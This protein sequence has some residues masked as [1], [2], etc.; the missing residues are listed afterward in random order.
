MRYYSLNNPLLWHILHEPLTR[1]TR[2][3]TRW[4]HKECYL[5]FILI[6]Y[7]IKCCRRSRLMFHQSQL[8]L[9]LI[10]PSQIIIQMMRE[11]LIL[12]S[13]MLSL[14]IIMICLEGALSH[15][16]RIHR[17]CGQITEPEAILSSPRILLCWPVTTHGVKAVGCLS[18]PSLA[19]FWSLWNRIDLYVLGLSIMSGLLSV[20]CPSSFVRM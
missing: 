8:S 9:I 11:I 17:S 7:L 18:G 15:L 14:E 10:F 3:L 20:L 6:K 13:G 1:K 16:R 19:S 12:I 4:L 5:V 2:S